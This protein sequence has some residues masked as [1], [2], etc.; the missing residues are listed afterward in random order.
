MSTSPILNRKQLHSSSTTDRMVEDKQ[1]LKEYFDKL[2][3]LVPTIPSHHESLSELQFIQY[4]MEYILELQQLLNNDTNTSSSVW[5]KTLNKLAA[6]MKT[7]FPNISASSTFNTFISSSPT[8]STSEYEN[9]RLL[10]LNQ[11]SNEDI[12]R[13][14]LSSI[15][16]ENYHNQSPI[17]YFELWPIL[18]RMILV[19][20]ILE[21]VTSSALLPSLQRLKLE[22]E[23]A[24]L[25]LKDGRISDEKKPTNVDVAQALDLTKR[26]QYEEAVISWKQKMFSRYEFE[27][28]G[29][30][31]TDRSALETKYFE[32]IQKMK[33]N[34]KMP[35]RIFTYIESDP[36]CNAKDL[37][38]Y[39]TDSLNEEPSH[40]ALGINTV[41]KRR[42]LQSRFK[43]TDQDYL[44]KTN[45]VNYKPNPDELRSNHY[46]TLPHETMYIMADLSDNSDVPQLT[47]QYVLCTIEYYPNGTVVLKPDFNIGKVPYMIETGTVGNEVYQYYLEHSST[48]INMDD[49]IKETRLLNEVSLRHQTY[50]MQMVGNE[51]DMPPPSIL[52]LHIFGEIVSAKNFEYDDLYVY[53]CLDLP[54][55]WY[56]DPSM[57]FAGYTNTCTT[58]TVDKDDVAY[59]SHPFEFEVWYKPSPG[60]ADHELPRM[61][62]I[63]FQVA[64]QDSW[65]RHRTEGYTYLDI[66]NTPGSYNETLLCWRPRGEHIF[67]ELRRFFIGGSHELEDISYVAIPRQ[68]QGEKDNK[69]L[70]RFGFRTISTG[71]L[72]VRYYVVY[73]SQTFAME[74]AKSSGAHVM[75]RYGF[76]SFLANI[77]TVIAAFHQAKKRA[78][79]VQES[80]QQFDRYVSTAQQ[81]NIETNKDK[82]QYEFQAETRQLLHIVAK[83]LYSDKEIFIRELISNAN[84]ALEKLRYIQLADSEVLKS[85]DDKMEIHI[86]VDDI[87]RTITIK[88]TGIGMTKEELIQNLGTI[89]RSGSKVFLDELKNEK[90][91]LD[92]GKIIGQFGVGF[93]SIFMVSQAVEVVSRS[94]KPN[95]KAYRWTSDGF[96]TYQI[97][98]IDDD[99]GR[100]TTIRC[101]LKDDCA[102]FSK[103]DTVKQII[104]KYSNFVSA[105]I[106][107][108]DVRINVMKAL[109]LEDAKA[110][111]E[112]EHTEFYRFISGLHDKPR[113]TLQYKIDV[114]I[115]VRALLYIPQYKPNIFDVT[116][117]ADIGISLYSRKVMIQPKANQL[118][119]R[120]LRFVKGVVDSE[121]IPL[122]LSRELLQDSNLI[123]KIRMLLTQ[124]IV[125]FLQTEST[126]DKTKYNEFYEDYK[127]FF[128]EGI[129]RTADQGEKEDIA[130]LLR[131]ESS[132]EE[133]GLLISLDD[134]IKR[135]QTDQKHIYYLAAPSRDLAENSPYYEAIRQR[136]YEVLYVYESHDEVLLMQL[137]EFD[138]K[139]LKSVESELETETKKDDTIIV[140]DSRSLTQEEAAKLKEW[141]LKTFSSKIKNVKIN[142]K[143]DQ[144]PCIIT[145][146]EMGAVRHFLKS[147]LLQ[148]GKQ[149]DMLIDNAMV[150]AGLVEDPRLVLTN[151]NK[152][153]EKALEKY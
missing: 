138:K 55:N 147:N 133:E 44:P 49:L 52:K 57:V 19:A 92:E 58:T 111:K 21:R 98:Q 24:K 145:T 125:R 144:H 126:K 41:R 39:M 38:Y 122:N 59:Y 85:Q 13:S 4:V 81:P 142:T 60:S 68:F 96:G 104:K 2:A 25:L 123:R 124:R 107:L 35:Q 121:D 69:P 5:S 115:N 87:N 51:F 26:S 67:N 30:E 31:R 108:N 93:Y 14:P 50:L 148:R 73:Q 152:L 119:P 9:N 118:L 110:I 86:G 99:I 29:R 101:L 113:Y 61:P 114:P 71:S 76:D 48:K 94:Y 77:N 75:N 128:K 15:N 134:Y 34:R 136:G 146:T 11:L 103:D 20:V 72:Y 95:E 28:Y 150:T 100:G 32:D 105:P 10:L 54:N 56:A 135:M 74:R 53:Y 78:V 79:E 151:L 88:D 83:S 37:D 139:K 143:L 64:S 129:V 45:L 63:Y 84:D 91:G 116:Q 33:A 1:E 23:M 106:Y 47:N 90:G 3:N 80:T 62:K 46:A 27:Y 6:T 18:L 65:G 141:L 89:A 153:L 43:I 149:A 132:R 97:E 130:T 137:G 22:D 66:Q 36:L 140:G 120:W 16:I 17:K 127:L 102:E 112:D 40:V 42:V 109:W 7:S 70:S 131:F 8:S 12:N 117:D 82:E